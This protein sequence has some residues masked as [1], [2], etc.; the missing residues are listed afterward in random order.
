MLTQQNGTPVLLKDVAK[1]ELGHTQRLGIAGRDDD[2]DVVEAIVLMRRGDKTLEVLQRIEAEVKKMNTENVLP[3]GVQIVSYYN[4]RDLIDVTTNTVLHNLLFGVAL[5]FLIQFVFLG[6]LRSAIIVSASIPVALF[7]SVLIM[8]LRGDSANLLSVGA[9][10][11]GIIVDATVIMV[12]NIFRHLSE[13]SEVHTQKKKR[14]K[15][16]AG[17]V[18]VSS[19]VFFST[20]I[21]IAAF[22]P[23]FTMQGV[24]GQ[25]F[26]PMAK[27]YGYAMI[28][29]LLATFMVAPVLSAFLL[30]DRV[31]RTRTADHARAASSLP[32]AADVRR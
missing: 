14:R 23:L 21:I 3:P 26:G 5:L 22:L 13:G 29:A 11:F 32:Q 31:S 17:A 15:I 8:Y 1:T 9:I 6:N 10:D 27:T 7:F 19:S 24:E 16:L 12:E 20:A 30:P 18:E 2:N 28:G 25:I 4:R